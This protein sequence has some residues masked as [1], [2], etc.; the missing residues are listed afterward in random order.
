M[1]VNILFFRIN[2]KVGVRGNLDKAFYLM[3]YIEIKI[4]TPFSVVYN[5]YYH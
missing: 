1:P 4:L 2:D 5:V 3:Y